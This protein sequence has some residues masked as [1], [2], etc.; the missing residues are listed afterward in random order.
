MGQ[1]RVNS[2]PVII[3]HGLSARRLSGPT[4]VAKSAFSQ[5]V[6]RS[7]ASGHSFGSLNPDLFYKMKSSS[8]EASEKTI[9]LTCDDALASVLE[10]ADIIKGPATLFVITD[11]VGKINRWPGQPAWVPEEHCLGWSDIRYLAQRGWAIGAH[12]CR[13]P[14]FEDLSPV[15][16]KNEILKSVH[17]IE[18][19]LG[20]PCSFFAYPYGHAPQSAR[21]LIQEA[22]LIAFGTEPGWVHGKSDQTHLPRLDLYDIVNATAHATWAWQQPGWLGLEWLKLKRSVGRM[23]KRRL[24][25]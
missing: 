17:T 22:N 25:A 21:D 24:I 10:M 20:I 19:R 4:H 2:F 3:A 8:L 15:E 7:L 1:I 9:Y 18:D 12:S 14:S 11:Y 5:W 23:K 13:H 6:R 16:L